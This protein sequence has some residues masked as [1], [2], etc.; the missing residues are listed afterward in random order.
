MTWSDI[1][2]PLAYCFRLVSIVFSDSRRFFPWLTR[3]IIPFFYH[4]FPEI[5]RY[6]DLNGSFV[7]QFIG[8]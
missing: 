5:L 8:Q 4:P 6:I 3:F 1:E 7:D 2:H